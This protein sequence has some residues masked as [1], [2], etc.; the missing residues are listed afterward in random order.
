MPELDGLRVLRPGLELGEIKKGRFQPAHA[1]A[2]WLHT[3]PEECSLAPD[4]R[5]LAAYLHGES[6]QSS[7]RGWVLVKVGP[8]SLG[9]G[10]G[11]GSQLKNHYPKGLRK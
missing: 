11:D 10:K 8:Y 5:E 4:S 3:A 2:L 1:L 9:W 7:Q 6:L